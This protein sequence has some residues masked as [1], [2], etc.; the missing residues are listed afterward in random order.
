MAV[1]RGKFIRKAERCL[2]KV[3]CK[4]ASAGSIRPFSFLL[5]AVP[6]SVEGEGI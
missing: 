6:D 4:S 1:F 3:V 5:V 2:D